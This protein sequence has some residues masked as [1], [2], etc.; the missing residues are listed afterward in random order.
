MRKLLIHARS[1]NV[2]IIILQALVLKEA[3]WQ[4]RPDHTLRSRG[5][6]SPRW[7]IHGSGRSRHRE[8]VRVL[9][10]A[11]GSNDICEIL[12]TCFSRGGPALTNAVIRKRKTSKQWVVIISEPLA[13]VPNSRGCLWTNFWSIPC[14]M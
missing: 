7:P 9:R 11:L 12:V 6:V 13:W 14:L 3:I 4:S 10:G 8:N 2:N 5:N 1:T